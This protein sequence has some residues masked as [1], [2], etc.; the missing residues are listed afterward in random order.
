MVSACVF[1]VVLV[2]FRVRISRV[3][4]H[5]KCVVFHVGRL[6]GCRVFMLDICCAAS[7]SGV[8]GTKAAVT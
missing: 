8:T 5:V 4:S 3:V 2:V 6:F 1:R 7:Q